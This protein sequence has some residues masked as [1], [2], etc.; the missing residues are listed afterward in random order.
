MRLFIRRFKLRRATELMGFA[1]L[2]AL[3]GQKSVV[4]MV[5]HLEE[6]GVS[7]KSASYRAAAD[8]ERFRS[9]LSALEAEGVTTEEL[10]HRIAKVG[11]NSPIRDETVVE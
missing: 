2:W 5:K 9:E 11:A 4:G 7:S 3:S 1:A 6:G 8:L 10:I